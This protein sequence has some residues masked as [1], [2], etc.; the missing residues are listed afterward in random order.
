M[1]DFVRC[2]LAGEVDRVPGAIRVWVGACHPNGSLGDDWIL[3]VRCRM[4]PSLPSWCAWRTVRLLCAVWVA[5]FVCSAVSARP[6][7]VLFIG[8]SYVYV[9]DLPKIFQQVAVGAG[10]EAPEIRMHAPG[11]QTLAGHV[12]DQALQKI[13]R[14]PCDV[15][16]LQEQSQIPAIAETSAPVRQMFFESC[17]AL[18]HAI[19]R[20]HPAVRVVFYQTWARH[21]SA[22]LSAKAPVD[23][24]ADAVDMQAR[25]SRW[26][27]EAARRASG[28]VAPVGD[29]WQANYR[30]PHPVMLHAQDG[31]HPTVAGTYLAALVLVSVVYQV[32]P[33]TQFDGPLPP[34]VAAH[35]R[36]LA[37][38]V[39]APEAGSKQGR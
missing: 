22:W 8:N 5:W 10:Q 26:Y 18:T 21:P 23:L 37:T 9:N 12:R 19:R 17:Q 7:K 14:E 2:L 15:V 34:Q 35:L 13:L 11:G 33:E 36:M 32:P 38:T 31:S 6:L 20:V 27:A 16:V 29:A 3:V 24:G 4:A 1:P 39:A 28:E 25:L 30:S